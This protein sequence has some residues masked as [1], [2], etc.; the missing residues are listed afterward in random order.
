MA[1]RKPPV[2]QVMRCVGK[3]M[4]K[5]AHFTNNTQ[6][7][8]C[9]AAL[10][11]PAAS[12][13][14]ASWD[15]YANCRLNKKRNALP[16]SISTLQ[17][18]WAPEHAPGLALRSDRGAKNKFFFIARRHRTKPPNQAVGSFGSGSISHSLFYS[19][20]NPRERKVQDG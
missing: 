13:E 17:R 15:E 3:E 9:A 10:A 4:A 7:L 18:W 5:C 12:H 6:S 16:G 8:G 14:Y 19:T 11:D 1:A 2:P 20:P